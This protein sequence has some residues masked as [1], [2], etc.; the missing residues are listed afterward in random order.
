MT[1]PAFNLYGNINFTSNMDVVRSAVYDQTC[2]IVALVDNYDSIS[3]DIPNA[4]LGSVL[5]PPY[6]AVMQY[7]DGNVQ[8]F[9]KEY[10]EYLG[11]K[12][13]DTFMC[14]LLAASARGFNLVIYVP[15]DEANNLKFVDA[16]GQYMNMAYG[17][18]IGND[19]GLPFNFNT[20]FMPQVLC[21]LYMHDLISYQELLVA[22]P[23]NTMLSEY[24]IPKLAL[25]MRFFGISPD[26]VSAQIHAYLQR[27]KQHDNTYLPRAVIRSK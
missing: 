3:R 25:E 8:G 10:F 23:P 13:A 17:V 4:A 12:E 22:Y 24:I 20:N 9:Y 21:R 5:L 16:L 26:D 6:G 11:S 7:L 18:T 15:R 2:K 27:I 1:V 14:L 19:E